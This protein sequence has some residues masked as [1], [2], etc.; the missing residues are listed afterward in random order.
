[1]QQM[2]QTQQLTRFLAKIHV[3]DQDIC[4]ALDL[5]QYQAQVERNH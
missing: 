4:W 5:I 1:M 3:T 2:Q